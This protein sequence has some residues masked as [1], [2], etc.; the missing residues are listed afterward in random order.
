[1]VNCA[2]PAVLDIWPADGPHAIYMEET[3][4]ASQRCVYIVN[5][6]HW[7]VVREKTDRTNSC[8]L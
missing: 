7:I 2:G 4:A 3:R 8:E 1:M 6:M 5:K